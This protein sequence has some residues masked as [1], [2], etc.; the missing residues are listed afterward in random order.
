M[1]DRRDGKS[2]KKE[3]RKEDMGRLGIGFE[4]LANTT[5]PFNFFRELSSVS[6]TNLY[7]LDSVAVNRHPCRL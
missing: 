4:G 2:K 5:S 6:S 7:H 1:D 3:E